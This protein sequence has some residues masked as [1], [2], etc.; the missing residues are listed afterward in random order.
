M[1]RGLVFFVDDIY[2]VVVGSNKQLPVVCVYDGSDAASSYDIIKIIAKI[3][4]RTFLRWH[5]IC[6]MLVYGKP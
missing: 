2:A 4:E 6:A 1:L 5:H 3:V